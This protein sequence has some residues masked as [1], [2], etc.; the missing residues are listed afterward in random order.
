MFHGLDKAVDVLH[1]IT[2]L[3]RKLLVIAAVELGIDLL[4]ISFSAVVAPNRDVDH[5]TAKLAHNLVSDLLCDFGSGGAVQAD[6][7]LR[8]TTQGLLERINE[9]SA[10]HGALVSV[11]SVIF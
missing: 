10:L 5:M 2:E 9:F 3:A 1:R 11:R 8:G 4:V 7:A 6:G